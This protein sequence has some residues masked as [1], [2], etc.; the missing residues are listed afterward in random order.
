[1][2]AKLKQLQKLI[3]TQFKNIS[4]LTIA[5][6]HK[7][8][9]AEINSKDF[10]ER[11][12]FLGDSV[13]SSVVADYLFQKYPKEDE[14]KLSQLKSQIVSRL[15]LG[16]WAKDINLGDY[17]YVSKGEQSSGGR[18]RDS[19]LANAF[20]ALI[21]AVYLDLGYEAAR[22]FILSQL[23][24]QKR[25]VINDPKSKFQELMQSQFQTLPDYRVIEETG[26][27]HEKLFE[28]GVYHDKELLGVGKGHSKK[29]A[30]QMAARNALKTLRAK[31][32]ELE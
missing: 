12:E 25:L 18:D 15:N 11:L 24:K 9:A 19:I 3:D 28:I 17:I 27:D 23:A 32:K 8:Y 20:E 31:K 6:T 4:L 16:K 22:K 5:L 2:S 30:Q 14:G 26:P 10:N 21:A 29:D 13:L 7:S 1:M